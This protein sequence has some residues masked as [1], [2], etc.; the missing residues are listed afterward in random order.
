MAIRIERNSSGGAEV[1]A[2]RIERESD[3]DLEADYLVEHFEG[4]VF[5]PEDLEYW[6]ARATLS[7]EGG[8]GMQ[9]YEFSDGSALVMRDGGRVI[10]AGF[11]RT[12]LEDEEFV[13]A[14]GAIVGA[15]TLE[16]ARR[17]AEFGDP[18]ELAR[19]H[20]AIEVVQAPAMEAGLSM[21]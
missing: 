2:I 11:R 17:V 5:Y 7:E 10:R 4:Y 8:T 6:V 12:E 1:T 13:C 21:G 14:L 3:T 9:R 20:Q 16:E 15:D 19:A 18:R